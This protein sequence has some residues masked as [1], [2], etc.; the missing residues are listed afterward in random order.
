MWKQHTSLN[1]Q[2]NFQGQLFIILAF[3]IILIWVL[4]PGEVL[5]KRGEEWQFLFEILGIKSIKLC[6]EIDELC[7]FLTGKVLLITVLNGGQHL[8]S[9]VKWL[10]VRPLEFLK[11]AF[12]EF[13]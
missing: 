13:Q 10:Q 4:T 12:V 8:T 1:K 9:H 6:L 3:S 7:Y 5:A 2:K 11:H